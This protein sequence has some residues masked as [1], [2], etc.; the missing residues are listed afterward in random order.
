MELRGSYLWVEVEVMHD[1]GVCACEI[2]TLATCA[3]PSTSAQGC[4]S[5][6]TMAKAAV[7]SRMR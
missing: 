1:H 2:E 4:K 6:R 7:I 3:Q 5:C